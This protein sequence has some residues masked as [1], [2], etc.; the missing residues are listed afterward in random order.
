MAAFR[1]ALLALLAL[2]ALALCVFEYSAPWT[3]RGGGGVEL[4]VAL[5]LFV[6][7]GF[8]FSRW[9]RQMLLVLCA[10]PI[11]TF[12]ART[13]LNAD[14]DRQLSR[15]VANVNY[16]ADQVAWYRQKNGRF[17]TTLEEAAMRS[18]PL[19][20]EAEMDTYSAGYVVSEKEFTICCK[21]DFHHRHFYDAPQARADYPCYSSSRGQILPLNEGPTPR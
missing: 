21:G 3:G 16:L 14:S 18:V 19:C 10:I 2:P 6:G 9:R 4:A 1:L 17:P 5:L 20:P 8:Q 15:C 11:V 12:L 7:A 13:H